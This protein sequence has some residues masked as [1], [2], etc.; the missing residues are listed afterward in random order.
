MEGLEPLRL[1]ARAPLGSTSVKPL[2]REA[3]GYT[4]ASGSALLVDLMVLWVLVHYYSWWY[5]AAATT[6]FLA[7]MVVAYLLSVRLAFK[8]HRLQDWRAEFISFA[9]IG[10]AGLVVNATAIFIAVKYFGLNYLVAKCVAA[11]F[12]FVYNF[13]SR[14]QLLFVQ[15]S[16]A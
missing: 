10:S 14:R 3:L 1:P 7:G 11:G 6:S 4:V 12:T 16:P 2:F 15:R 13:I 9:A 8:H 5:L